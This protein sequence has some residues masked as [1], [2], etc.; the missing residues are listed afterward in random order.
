MTERVFRERLLQLWLSSTV[1]ELLV[2]RF[3]SVTALRV[4]TQKV[5]FVAIWLSALVFGFVMYCRGSLTDQAEREQI[6]AESHVK[7]PGWVVLF[8]SM[9]MLLMMQGAAA[10][11][12]W[13]ARTSA[14]WTD[15]ALLPVK[16]LFALGITARVF[17]ILRNAHLRR[18]QGA[19]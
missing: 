10:L 8:C 15:L 19:E 3:L 18:V 7:E 14:S 16:L 11:V 1:V 6:L 13:T 12:I 5:V 4:E 9:F 17:E 2:S